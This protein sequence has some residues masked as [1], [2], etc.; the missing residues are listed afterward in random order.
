MNNSVVSSSLGDDMLQKG[1]V[2]FR[3]EK[4]YKNAKEG[5]SFLIRETVANAIHAAILRQNKEKNFDNPKV[6][7]SIER[8]D[9]NIKIII[10]DNGEGFTQENRRYFSSLDLKNKEKEKLKLNPQGQGR[11]AM[12]YFTDF[13]EYTSIF[14]KEEGQLEHQVF[15]Y[16]AQ[17]G[18]S[19]LFDI[20]TQEGVIISDSNIGT[21]LEM[22]IY[23]PT[24]LS[25][26]KNFFAKYDTLDGF[27]NWLIENFFPFFIENEKLIVDV[28]MDSEKATITKKNIEQNIQ[29]IEFYVNLQDSRASFTLWLIPNKKSSKQKHTIVCFARQLKVSLVDA[30]FEYEIDL[31][32]PCDWYLT[33]SYFD[34]QV[35]QRGDK[36]EIPSINI[37]R[38]QK[39]LCNNL[40]DYFQEQIREN[41]ETT[42]NNIDSTKKQYSS[43][44][45]FVEEEIVDQ[46]NIVLRSK[47]IIKDAISRKAKAEERFWSEKNPRGEDVDKLI[48]SSLRI[49]IE[50]RRRVLEILSEL[51]KK[52]NNEGQVQSILESKI[53]DL[54]LKR[55]TELSESKNINH[56]NNLWLLD[57]KFSRFSATK[58][59]KSTKQGEAKADIYLWTDC[60]DAKNI[61]EILIL[62][63]K[64]TSKAH[65]AGSSRENMIAQVN[66]YARMAYEKPQD[67]FNWDIVPSRILYTGIIL[68]TKK[69]I[70]KELRGD[71]APSNVEKIPFLNSSYYLNHKF[72]P[73]SSVSCPIRIELYSYEDIYQLASDRN[74]VFFDLLQ[75]GII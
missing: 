54:I 46:S 62:E 58:K 69:D 33:S 65:N 36:L 18:Q 17:E 50:H 41:R 4:L 72:H 59:A 74:Q 64:S 42:R 5:F 38:I 25:R 48:N 68:A 21:T 73:T 14:K 26:A 49:Y 16:P 57:D 1:D 53:H 43:I 7:L 44:G 6:S 34:E 40:D 32:D 37:K 67:F 9:K 45:V 28:S 31:N 35:D 66:R 39:A 56:L 12:V 8:E 75:E 30:T 55:G 60:K 47:D 27:E 23:S 61:N 71:N 10:Q 2:E 19:I 70:E 11:L 3:A 13:S 52:F 22:Q 15:E 29:N 20:E 63:L 24:S 51:V